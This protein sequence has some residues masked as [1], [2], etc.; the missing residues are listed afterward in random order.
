MSSQALTTWSTIALP[1]LDQIAA[2][3]AAVG[4]KAPGRRHTTLQLNYVYAGQVAAQFQRFC[5]DLHT[6]AANAMLGHIT[7]PPN[8]GLAAVISGA[9]TRGR[10]LDRGNPGSDN[11]GKD[12]GILG[13]TG[14]WDD[15]RAHDARNEDRRVQ[16]E[17]LLTW[18][19][20]IAHQD[21]SRLPDVNL[22]LARV[23]GWRSACHQFA[24]S[25]DWVVAD[26]IR[27]MVGTRP[28]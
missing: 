2:A 18:R 11:I 10:K 5:R 4:G 20:A 25:F 15:V 24:I 14:I 26:R 13:L 27:R 1:Q 17:E 7:V 12:F 16:L 23:R 6:E 3:H 19:N 8:T 28:W 22:K 9:L 21:F